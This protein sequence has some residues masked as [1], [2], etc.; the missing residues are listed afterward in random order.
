M[1]RRQDRHRW[2][3]PG[4]TH[5]EAERDRE[6]GGQK[7]KTYATGQVERMFVRRREGVTREED[8]E[9]REHVTHIQTGQAKAGRAR[10]VCGKHK[11]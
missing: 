4:D 8:E 6:C 9:E 5:T 11:H 2:T 10:N 7:A 3:R 1:E